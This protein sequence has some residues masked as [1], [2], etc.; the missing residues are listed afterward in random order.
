MYVAAQIL[1]AIDDVF[2]RTQIALNLP[3]LDDNYI[4]IVEVNNDGS[5]SILYNFDNGQE[6]EITVKQIRH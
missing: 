1:D 4:S 5:A 6:F 3:Q 2:V